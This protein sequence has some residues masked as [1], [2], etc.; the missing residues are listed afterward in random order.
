VK[1]RIDAGALARFL[2]HG[3][4]HARAP[5]DL[6]EIVIPTLDIL[7]FLIGEEGA[8]GEF[9]PPGAGPGFPIG[10][11]IGVLIRQELADPAAGANPEWTVPA[12]KIWRFIT[13]HGRLTT[14]A[15]AGMREVS[16]LVH[17]NDTAKPYVR[18]LPALEQAA[19][20]AFSY[21]WA[22]WAT[23]NQRSDSS[24]G[25]A[26][27]KI[28]NHL[29]LPEP[30]RVRLLTNNIKAGDQWTQLAALIGEFDAA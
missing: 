3:E 4:G 1:V 22:E 17:P 6:D 8:V 27:E 11:G 10:T 24:V 12:G 21:T 26:T 18:G 29:L 15:T 20:L 5:G 9:I 7:P 23:D 16:F 14:D 30:F 25:L 28:P 19:S 2:G 13:V